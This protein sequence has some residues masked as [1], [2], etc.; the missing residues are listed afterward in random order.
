MRGATVSEC[1]LQEFARGSAW[2]ETPLPI[3]SHRIPMRGFY[4]QIPSYLP[5]SAGRRA[6][7]RFTRSRMM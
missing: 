6:F 2:A 5:L 3:P 4:Q 7:S 1:L